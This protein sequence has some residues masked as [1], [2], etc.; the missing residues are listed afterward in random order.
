MRR[1]ATTVF[2]AG[3][4]GFFAVSALSS[5]L[6]VLRIAEPGFPHL[7]WIGDAADRMSVQVAAAGN[8]DVLATVFAAFLS[9]AV[10]SLLGVAI[11]LLQGVE[12]ED[13]TAG[14]RLSFALLVVAGTL[15]AAFRFGGFSAFA[16]VES[17]AVFAGILALSMVAIGFD[18]LIEIDEDDTEEED[19]KFHATALLIGRGMAREAAMRSAIHDL[20]S[21]NRIG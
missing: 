7:A 12:P 9:L 1:M 16:E 10:A 11:W 13:R 4:I 2:I 14:E 20:Q 21:R 19:A 18:R 15:V 5:S 17:L 8:A 3:W 6:A